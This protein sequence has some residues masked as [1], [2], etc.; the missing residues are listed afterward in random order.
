[1]PISV[2]KRTFRAKYPVPAEQS[3]R[4]NILST[5][6]KLYRTFLF[7]R[8]YYRRNQTETI[9]PGH[10]LHTL[11]R[12]A[13]KKDRVFFQSLLLKRRKVAFFY[14]FCPLAQPSISLKRF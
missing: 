8:S 7:T 2:S 14:L 5:L 6:W 3:L 1:M 12:H 10:F 4:D 9:L 13:Q 11:L